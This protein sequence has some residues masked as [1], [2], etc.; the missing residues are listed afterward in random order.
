MKDRF[1][2]EWDKSALVGEGLPSVLETMMEMNELVGRTLT[3]DKIRE[4]I[5]TEV[6]RA[7]RI[8]S[9]RAQA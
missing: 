3:H 9:E 4:L 1:D 7:D 2:N 6:E 8:I 5:K